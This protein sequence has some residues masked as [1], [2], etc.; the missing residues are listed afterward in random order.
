MPLYSIDSPTG[1]VNYGTNESSGI[2]LSVV[3]KNLEWREG[4]SEE[5]NKIAMDVNG[6]DGDGSY[7]DIHTGENG[8][9]RKVSKETMITYLKRYGIPE[10][11]IQGLLTNTRIDL[12]EAQ[13]MNKVLIEN[14]C[15]SCENR[16]TKTCAK[17]HSAYYCRKDCQVKDWGIHKY[18]C[19]FS[20]FPTKT[21]KDSV[22]G[23]LFPVKGEKPLMVEV[24]LESKMLEG[25]P[26]VVTKS[27]SF[28]G[29]KIIGHSYIFENSLKPGKVLK[30]TLIVEYRD[31]FLND[32]SKP[33]ETI[34][35]VSKNRMN[36]NWKGPLLV[37]KVRG[38][39]LFG[40]LD[41]CDIDLR[42]FVDII[43]F[44]LTYPA[45]R[46]FMQ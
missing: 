45:K 38:Q 34:E 3:D 6:N 13:E 20:L 26:F 17:C 5:V 32:N 33:N 27:S 35:I 36:H 24:P 42:D 29:T 19:N 28:L 12:I 11:H 37:T 43:D 18:I 16:T 39:D 23:M 8:Y 10:S 40:N 7:F 14:K 25:E 44:F 46:S 2:F 31:N 30:D 9:G 41:Y 21:K 4:E 15:F 22:Y 1:K